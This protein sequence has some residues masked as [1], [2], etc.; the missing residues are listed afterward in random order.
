MLN[1]GIVSGQGGL[2][3]SKGEGEELL[4]GLGV[5]MLL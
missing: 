5:I 4:E 2:G 1:R 3:G